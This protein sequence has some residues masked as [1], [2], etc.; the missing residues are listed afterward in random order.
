MDSLGDPGYAV[1][2]ANVFKTSNITAL[3][4]ACLN[5]VTIY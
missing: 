2:T 4:H 3:L 1:N 5:F